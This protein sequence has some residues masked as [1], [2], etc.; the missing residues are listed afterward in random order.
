MTKT[1][2]RGQRRRAAAG[3]ALILGALSTPVL[4][5][6]QASAASSYGT[7]WGEI[8]NCAQFGPQACWNARD[9]MNWAKSVAEWRY[10]NIPTST[11]TSPMR[12]GIAP[13]RAP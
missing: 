8:V 9:A 3:A 6:P 13:G 12:S 5:A 11:T 2:K 1:V 7:S 10:P 4:G